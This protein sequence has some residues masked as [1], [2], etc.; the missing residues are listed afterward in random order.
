MSVL[1]VGAA[2]YIGS[3]CTKYFQEKNIDVVA[4]DNLTTGHRESINVKK[5][6]DIDIRSDELD[7]VFKENDIDVVIHFAANS[8]VEESVKDPYKYYNNNVYGMMTLLE[9]MMKNNC[10]KI[11]FSSTAATYGDVK[12]MPI[13]ETE[14]TNP[15]NPYGRTKLIMEKMMKDFDNAYD[16]KYVSLR[17]FNAAGADPSG[18]IGEDH[19]KETHLIPIVLQQALGKRDKIV[20]FGD[21]YP[22][23]DGS[24]VRDYIH[25]MDLADAHYLAYK[26]LLDGG[27]SDIFN[28]GSGKGYTVK[29][30]VNI[31]REVTGIDIV[32]EIGERRAGDPP[33]LIASSDK[34]IKTLGWERKYDDV[35]IIIKDAWNF[36]KKHPSGYEK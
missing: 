22:T 33:S 27:K 25:V 2:G 17:Y 12:K 16:V 31:A 1:I 11:V 26:Y 21:D 5:F 35:K 32:S 29:E 30:I 28:L 7:R 36:H 18:D 14:I 3:N 20:I 9:K 24:C 4:V 8:I 13:L 19:S 15:T 6:Y 34:I 23:R 10:K